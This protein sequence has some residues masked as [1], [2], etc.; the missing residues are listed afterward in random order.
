VLRP[1]GMRQSSRMNTDY[2]AA[3]TEIVRRTRQNP[4]SSKRTALTLLLGPRRITRHLARIAA[5]VADEL[6]CIEP[7]AGVEAEHEALTRAARRTASSL[8][9]L[10]RRKDLRAFERFEALADVNFA[11]AELR[12]LE[13][14]GYR[15]AR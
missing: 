11:Q 9:E 5:T 3:L 2:Q 1:A 10:A 8:D 6:G 15:L 14:R 13:A 4:L 7:P 12:A